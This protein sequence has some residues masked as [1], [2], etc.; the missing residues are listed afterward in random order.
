MGFCTGERKSLPWGKRKPP[1]STIM[2]LK[3]LRFLQQSSGS[4]TARVP[5]PAFPCRYPYPGQS[6]CLC[7]TLSLYFKEGAALINKI[8]KRVKARVFMKLQPQGSFTEIESLEHQEWPL[9][10]TVLWEAVANPWLC[11]TWKVSSCS[12]SLPW[13]M[14]TG[15]VPPTSPLLL[16]PSLGQGRAELMGA[17]PYFSFCFASQGGCTDSLATSSAS[18]PPPWACAA[19]RNRGKLSLSAP[20]CLGHMACCCWGSS[21]STAKPTVTGHW[22]PTNI[23][24][25]FTAHAEVPHGLQAVFSWLRARRETTPAAWWAGTS[26]LAAEQAG[27]E[28]VCFL[29]V[30]NSLQGCINFISASHRHLF[31]LGATWGKD[32][33]RK[34]LSNVEPWKK[35]NQIPAPWCWKEH[36]DFPMVDFHSWSWTVQGFLQQQMTSTTFAP[37]LILLADLQILL[38]RFLVFSLPCQKDFWDWQRSGELSRQRRASAA[39]LLDGPSLLLSPL[40]AQQCKQVENKQLLLEEGCEKT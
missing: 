6:M 28:H 39:E 20:S 2:L 32:L 37:S 10:S 17:T 3:W 19:P 9:M 24:E 4:N 12:F 34:R 36:R 27:Q 14:S 8:E 40:I 38:Q 21:A 18:C 13:P 26:S 29:L 7:K 25:T 5:Q 30:E 23:T 11:R 1:D 31:P 33:Q 16:Q 15:Q 22:A 35:P